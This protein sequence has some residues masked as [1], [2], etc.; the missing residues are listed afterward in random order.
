MLECTAV[1]SD[2][3]FFSLLLEL[4]SGSAEPAFDMPSEE[5]S[6]S[7]L[8]ILSTESLISSSSFPNAIVIGA[9]TLAFELMRKGNFF[10]IRCR[11][12]Q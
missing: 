4:T 11:A 10:R 5:V 7:L 1:L 12:V 9:Q 3:R 6:L 8:Y 2:K